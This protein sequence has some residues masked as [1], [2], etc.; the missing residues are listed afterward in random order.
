MMKLKQL[1]QNVSACP[2]KKTVASKDNDQVSEAS[3]AKE[4]STLPEVR[5]NDE[6]V[7]A[8]KAKS[9]P[10]ARKKVPKEETDTKEAGYSLNSN[11]I[12]EGEEPVKKSEKKVV[13][14]SK[15][16]SGETKKTSTQSVTAASM[17]EDINKP[18]TENKVNTLE[19]EETKKT[20]RR[21]WW[22]KKS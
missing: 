4:V 22:S 6:G 5:D 15:S 13:K 21:G 2:E 17:G 18:L 20:R 12:S 11:S 10:R 7:D 14:V 19:V 1:L 9:K 8:L 16:K 3:D